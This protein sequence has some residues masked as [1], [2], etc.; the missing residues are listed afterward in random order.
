MTRESLT[1]AAEEAGRLADAL[2][3]ASA[4]EPA[5]TGEDEG[6]GES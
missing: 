2:T 6:D 5:G 4:E 1:P 3:A